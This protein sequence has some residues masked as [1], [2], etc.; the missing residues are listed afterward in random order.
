M[1]IHSKLTSLRLPY[2]RPARCRYYRGRHQILPPTLEFTT[3]G[4]SRIKCDGGRSDPVRSSQMELVR[5]L[6]GQVGAGHNGLFHNQ[7]DPKIG[8]HLSRNWVKS[9]VVYKTRTWTLLTGAR[10]M[11]FDDKFW[12]QIL[13]TNFD[14]KFWR[15]ILATN[16]DDEFW[17]RILT[18]NFRRWTERADEHDA[19]LLLSPRY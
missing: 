10:V 7:G 11:T 17:R 12:R 1:L 19:L 18:G 16:F 15:Q 3:V 6:S 9:Y 5:V 14:D 13:M 8:I 2:D 4:S